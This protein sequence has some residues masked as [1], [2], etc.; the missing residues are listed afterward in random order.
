MPTLQELLADPDFR[1]ATPTTKRRILTD[2]V[3]SFAESSP[4]EQDR[5][6]R[7]SSAEFRKPPTIGDYIV[8]GIKRAAPEILPALGFIGGSVLGAGAG[9]A[10]TGPL[11]PLG[12]T[13]GAVVGGG[14]GYAAGQQAN[15]MISSMIP[16]QG[17]Q[18]VA[19]PPL[20][21][22]RAEG[23]VG[24]QAMTIGKDIAL[25]GA[26]E[27]LPQSALAAG[28]GM[29]SLM[30]INKAS[31]ADLAVRDAASRQGIP[32]TAGAASGSAPVSLVESIP[33]RFPIGRQTVEPQ[34]R[35]TQL[36]AQRAAERLSQAFAPGKTLEQ[37]GQA[38]QTEVGSIAKAQAE[39]PTALVDEAINAV[40]VTQQPVTRTQLGARLKETG[41][42][43]QGMRRRAASQVY[44]AAIASRGNDE[45]ALGSLHRVSSEIVAFE[46]RLQ[47]VQTPATGRAQGLKS[48]SSPPD[49]NVADLPQEALGDLLRQGGAAAESVLAGGK[50]PTGSLTA[51]FIERYGLA[52]QGT[53][54]LEEAIAIQ[55]RLRGLV[56]NATDDVTRRQ[57]RNMMDAISDDIGA[58]APGTAL[59]DAARFY[60]TEVAVYF[61][62]QAPL[63]RLL[64]K[65]P[66]QVADQILSANRP[67]RL[68]EIV[69][70][71]PER[72]QR[73]VQQ[74]VLER[75]KQ[76][77]IR[78]D[79][80]EVDP[81]VFAEH[82]KAF[83]DENLGIVFG[84]QSGRVKAL[85]DSLRKNFGAGTSQD[86]LAQLL[87][88]QPEKIVNTLARGKFKS[89]DD[90]DAVWNVV[91]P[92]TKQEMRS[93]LYGEVVQNSFDPAT[94]MFSMQ[95]FLRQKEVV[96]QEMWDRMLTGNPGAALRDLETVFRRIVQF[97]QVAA[98]PSQ[99]SAAIL[100][101]SQILGAAGGSAA[102]G[103]STVLGNEDSVSFAKKSAAILIAVFS[104]AILGKAAMGPRGQA[105]LTSPPPTLGRPPASSTLDMMRS[106][107]PSPLGL[108]VRAIEGMTAGGRDESRKP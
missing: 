54:T 75:M 100:G 40:R 1:N 6:L 47:G 37:A 3:P 26:M 95:R 103:A 39:A 51:D 22:P 46:K 96:P 57:L 102:L 85:A 91:S 82:V 8:G 5:M 104:P 15:R 92:A 21:L 53:R 83:G 94:G 72:D 13:G 19:Q 20:N 35:E 52:T 66:S 7:E 44:D 50:L 17:G 97:N 69:R 80:G 101:P 28:R 48:A 60:K 77:S 59:A 62:R 25:G 4:A 23:G 63:R 33:A 99:T 10:A 84:A 45:V 16:E 14:V 12:A 79:T 61:A 42:T 41:E 58:V 67:E 31:P 55:Q 24:Q 107:A 88:A 70:I 34:A 87:T 89:L 65:E 64:D 90:F 76:K 32:L 18:F 68:R 29:R 81:V 36:A 73:L 56:R 49:V 11:A 74:A 105:M 106:G 108:G 27:L 93:A 38:L 71:F 43:V 9:A 78:V 30:G 2:Y 86:A 98:N